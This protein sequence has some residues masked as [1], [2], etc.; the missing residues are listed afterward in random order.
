LLIGAGDGAVGT[1]VEGCPVGVLV[2]GL[3][4]VGLKVIGL[5]V[6]GLLVGLA[7]VGTFV[8]NKV[9]VFCG[10][11]FPFTDS[12]NIYNNAIFYGIYVGI[13]TEKIIVRQS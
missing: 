10:R 13:S 7:D 8:V 4:E 12:S 6:V 3:A 11:T 1:L 2:V 9:V 5:L